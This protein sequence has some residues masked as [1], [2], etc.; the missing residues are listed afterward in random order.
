MQDTPASPWQTGLG[1]LPT[2]EPLYLGI[3][4]ATPDSFSDGG[5]FLAP[6]AALAQALQLLEQGARVLDVG[7]ESTRPDAAPV[8]PEEEW[9]RLEPVLARLRSELPHIPISLD[10]RHGS[11]AARGLQCGVAV[12]NDVTGFSDPELLHV[13][14]NSGCGLIAMRS[15][16]DGERFHMPPYGL[17]GTASAET[18]LAELAAVKDRLLAAGL[19]PGRI[20]LDPG[21]GFGLTFD[22]DLALWEALSRMPAALDWPAEKF[23]IGLSRKRF[24]AWQAGTP[25]LPV[26]ER[27]PLTAKAH[28]QAEALGYRVFRSHTGARPCLR[29][30]L[31][32]DAQALA[33]VQVDSWREAYRDILP[34]STLN[35]LEAAPLEGAFRT[36]VTAPPSPAC[37]LWA[38][39]MGG[40]LCGYAATGPCRDTGVDPAATAEIYALYFLKTYWGLGLGQALMAQAL[41][42]FRERGFSEAILWV[43]ERNS[44]A[45]RFY[46]AVGWKLN[47]P[48]RTIWQD[49]IALRECQYHI[50]LASPA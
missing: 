13:T 2:Q 24:L 35:Q 42:S 25:A 11:V 21:F 43:L 34:A 26:A 45:R 48:P 14:R 18:A 40:K 3:L 33:Q 1:L 47:G 44:R 46:E 29:L 8:A 37:R 50:L 39:V 27:D 12:I 16:M 23:C 30:A 6:D 10:T 41:A 15:R 36:M 38:T 20:L 19:Q 49:G 17:S 9:A 7:A 22:E 31:E 5:R 4:N 32:D 28:R